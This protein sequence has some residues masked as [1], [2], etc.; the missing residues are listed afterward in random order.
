M[1]EITIFSG[2]YTIGLLHIPRIPLDIFPKPLNHRGEMFQVEFLASDSHEAFMKMLHLNATSPMMPCAAPRSSPTFW[3]PNPSNLSLVV[4]RPKPPKPAG[5]LYLLCLLHD[6][7]LYPASLSRIVWSPSPHA[8]TMT[9]STVILTLVNTVYA[10]AH[11]H[12]LCQ[13]CEVLAIH[14]PSLINP[15]VQTSTSVLHCSQFIGTNSLDLLHYCWPPQ[16]T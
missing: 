5:V 7:D 9:W 12:L 16:Y 15:S 13:R 14:G 1:G 8:P 3:G 10:P 4:L 6:I 11:V 2:L